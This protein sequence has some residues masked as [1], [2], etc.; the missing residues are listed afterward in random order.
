MECLLLFVDL[1]RLVRTGFENVQQAT[2][3][4]GKV[5]KKKKKIDE[6]C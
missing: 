3:T 2:E 5:K 4:T 6:N 1:K